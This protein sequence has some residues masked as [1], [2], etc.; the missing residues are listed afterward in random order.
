MPVKR[1]RLSAEQLTALRVTLDSFTDEEVAVIVYAAGEAFTDSISMFEAA[2][3]VGMGKEAVVELS[4][5]LRD[6]AR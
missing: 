5:K 1:A 4:V 2:R 3:A 6:L